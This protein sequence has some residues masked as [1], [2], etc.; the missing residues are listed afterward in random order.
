[1][2]AEQKAFLDN[3]AP[4]AKVEMDRAGILASLTIA[5]AII[6]S[7]WGTSPLAK[8]HNY[9]G[10]KWREGCGFDYQEKITKEWVTDHYIDIVAKFRKYT[11]MAIGVKDHSD[12]LLRDRYKPLWG[13]KDYKD[14]CR[15]IRECGYATSPTYTETLIKTIETY[16]LNKYDGDD[17]VK[18][19]ISNGVVKDTNIMGVP[20]TAKIV[21]KKGNPNVR[22]GIKMEQV[23]GI[24][25]HNTANKSASAEDHAK[26]LQNVEDADQQYIS[27]HFFVDEDSIVQTV[28]ITEVCWHAGDGRGD[29]NMKTISIEICENGD[30]AKAE[31]NAQ[32]LNAALIS[33]LGNLK[34]Y[35]HQDWSGKYCPRVILARPNGWQ[36][37]VDGINKLLESTPA[38]VP[39]TSFAVRVTASILNIR[40]GAGTN[41]K[42]VGSIK[43]KGVYTI[44]EVKGDWGKLKSGVGFIHLGFVERA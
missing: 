21:A 35:K 10:I 16:G 25:N 39:T 13:V 28:P 40:E 8:G 42:V 4:L 18:L 15:I 32:K 27:V 12:F 33:T 3:I 19:T 6:E 29:G 43:D 26:W 34:I 9:F 2:T 38:P 30:M 17:K 31:A 24:T 44:T 11:S 7:N 36:I 22:T 1:M 37:F 20:F 5:Q 14:A 41:F 23:I